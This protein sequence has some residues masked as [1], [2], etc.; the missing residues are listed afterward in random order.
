MPSHMEEF[1]RSSTAS[2]EQQ[3]GGNMPLL[4]PFVGAFG[5]EACIHICLSLENFQM[6]TSQ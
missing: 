3:Q 5:T 2:K 4:P 6:G 1:T